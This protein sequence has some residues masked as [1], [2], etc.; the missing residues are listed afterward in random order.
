MKRT[1]LATVRSEPVVVGVSTGGTSPALARELRRRIEPELAGAGDLATLLTELRPEAK[2]RGN[3]TERR[4]AM[5]AI[6]GAPAV[7]KGLGE[8]ESNA[9]EEARRLLNEYV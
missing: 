2:R 3:S 8:G 5:R 9:R 4:A 1:T 6:V 7:W